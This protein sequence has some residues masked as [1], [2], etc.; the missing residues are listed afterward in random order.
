MAQNEKRKK[1]EYF[2]NFQKFASEKNITIEIAGMP[3][4]AYRPV[5][6][7]IRPSNGFKIFKPEQGGED[8]DGERLDEEDL[9][10]EEEDS[11]EED[12]LD[13]DGEDSEEDEGDD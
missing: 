12:E 11:D 6:E 1:S 13:E 4:Y 8:L 3:K 10:E 2:K 7:V 5:L 9:G